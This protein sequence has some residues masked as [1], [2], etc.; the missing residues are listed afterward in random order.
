MF[1]VDSISDLIRNDPVDLLLN[2]RFHLQK[3]AINAIN[4]HHGIRLSSWN[5][6]RNHSQLT[7]EHLDNLLRRFDLLSVLLLMLVGYDDIV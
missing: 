3:F 2:R 5:M 7:F 4:L 1:L 6:M